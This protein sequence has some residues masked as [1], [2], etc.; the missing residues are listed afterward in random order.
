M[1]TETTV[2]ALLDAA[3]ITMSDEELHLFVK[4]YPT[5]REGADDLYL[6]ETRHEEP[7]LVFDAAWSQP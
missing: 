6:P 3:Q 7:S 1:T 5:L 2:Q 4:V